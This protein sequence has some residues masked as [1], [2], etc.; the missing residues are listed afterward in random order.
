MDGVD[1]AATVLMYS[2]HNFSCYHLKHIDYGS[3][4]TSRIHRDLNLEHQ[5]SQEI[6]YEI[7]IGLIARKWKLKHQNQ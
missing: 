4:N 1:G 3:F 6:H 5:C 2:K 7:N